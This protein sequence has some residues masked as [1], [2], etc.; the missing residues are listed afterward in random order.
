MD[1]GVRPYMRRDIGVETDKCE[2]F[3][4]IISTSRVAVGRESG[5]DELNRRTQSSWT[6]RV[7]GEYPPP[8]PYFRCDAK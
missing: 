1:V 4:P 7:P 2:T 6:R 8:S 5:T 3:S